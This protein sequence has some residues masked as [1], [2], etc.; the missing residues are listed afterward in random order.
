LVSSFSGAHWQE[1]SDPQP[2]PHDQSTSG[3]YYPAFGDALAARLGVP[4]AIASTGQGSTEVAEW[5]PDAPHD[6]SDFASS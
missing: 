6:Y 4:V 3:S 2:G 5:V 1:A